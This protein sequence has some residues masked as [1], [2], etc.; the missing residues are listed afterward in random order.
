MLPKETSWGDSQSVA[1]H[2]TTTAIMPSHHQSKMLNAR[3]LFCTSLCVDGN[4]EE[5]AHDIHFARAAKP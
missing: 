4:A 2:E 1:S 3:S 5:S